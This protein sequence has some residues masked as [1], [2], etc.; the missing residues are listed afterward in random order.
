MIQGIPW[1]FSGK[2]S[3]IPLLSISSSIQW[4]YVVTSYGYCGNLMGLLK[5]LAHG[6]SSIDIFNN[7]AGQ[8]G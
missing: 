6:Q 8:R 5:L 7:A 4:G 3:V 2:D 1:W